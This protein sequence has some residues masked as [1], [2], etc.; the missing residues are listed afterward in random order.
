[1]H[2]VSGVLEELCAGYNFLEY[3]TPRTARVEKDWTRNR[4]RL[5]MTADLCPVY[6]N[7]CTALLGLIIMEPHIRSG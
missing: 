6:F 7:D 4:R 1:M 5:R 2:I 3:I